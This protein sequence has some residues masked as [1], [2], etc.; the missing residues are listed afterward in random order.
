MLL[1]A[2]NMSTP[3][4]CLNPLCPIPHKVFRNHAAYSRH[5]NSSSG[6][7]HHIRSA[8]TLLPSMPHISTIDK[9][10]SFALT[11]TP[12]LVALSSS[13]KPALLREQF[14]N[15]TV[16]PPKKLPSAIVVD[17]EC[18]NECLDV[19]CDVTSK[20][21]KVTDALLNDDNNVHFDDTPEDQNVAHA[22]QE[23]AT[24]NHASTS[25][26][27][28][29]D[30]L[31]T[32]DQKWTVALLKVL[33]DINAPDYA[34]GS[35]LAWARAASADEYSFYPQG[36]L[37]RSRNVEVLLK[38]MSN[39]TQ[40]LPNVVSVS[41][42]H[43][44]PSPIVVFD[45]VPQLLSLLQNRN[46][47]I[48]QNV[49][50]NLDNPLVRYES[51]DGKL[52]EALSGSVY[53][54]AYNRLITDPT[55][56]LFVPIIQWIDRTSVTGNDRFSLKPY[57]FTP[58]IF[59]E[60]F[61]RTIKAWGYH[62]FLPKS[63]TSSAQNKT[64]SPGDNI[65]NYHAQL[66]Q[67]LESFCNAGPRLKN[68]IL[69]IGPTGTIK[70]DIVTCILFVIQD[71]QEGD[72][73]CGRFGP[74]TPQIQ[75]HCRSCNVDYESLARPDVKCKYLYAAPMHL[76]AQTDHAETRQRWSQH[77]LDNAFNYVTFADPERG[78][79]GATPVET[80]H[81]FRKGLVEVVTYIVLENV[82]ASKKAALDNLALRFHHTH[83][84][85]C[86]H[87]FPSTTFSSGITNISK[88]SASERVG[89]VFLFVI[90]GHFNEGWTILSSAL[91][92]C[93]A[94]KE[95]P[96]KKKEKQK[97]LYQPK[98]RDIL[99]VFEAM[100][101][102]DEW[103]NKETFWL[104]SDTEY[105]KA[106]VSQSIRKLMKMCQQY[107]PTSK[108]NAWNFPKFHELLHILDDMSR[109]GSPLNFCAQR[110]ESLLIQAAKQ[111]GRR[112][113]K[114]HEGALYDLQAAQRLCYSLMIDRVHSRIQDGAP[115]GHIAYCNAAHSN[116]E[117]DDIVPLHEST[118]GASNAVLTCVEDASH[119][120]QRKFQVK[121]ST[122]TNVNLMTVD[123][124]LMHYLYDQFGPQVSFCTQYKRH[125]YTFRC[126]PAFNSGR[127]IYDWMII[128]FTKGLFPCR[129][130]AVV[131]MDSTMNPEEPLQLV[132]Q[133]A[134]SKTKTKSTLFQEWNWSPE[135]LTVSP[136]SIEAPCFVISIRDDHSLILETLARDKWAEQFTHVD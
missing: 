24:H 115:A 3:T 130:A 41:C 11:T 119:N 65:R 86:R 44:P 66:R 58:A 94:K 109:F 68:V 63:K 53:R 18:I 60:P 81:A 6:C 28:P 64:Q 15:T 42:P 97:R 21:D 134:T 83:R 91:E 13:K 57:M 7:S 79:F 77:R 76:I 112:A 5:L 82:P 73:L 48:Q 101:C 10:Q 71:M 47:M 61:R 17:T 37:D 69:P 93:H 59:T 55:K 120:M 122:Q 127:P 46:I 54:D 62:G 116:A 100:L 12:Q 131:F 129:L 78:I 87:T 90:L 26:A 32:I 50:L 128:K 9:R 39:A 114:R 118:K 16:P 117:L 23:D 121:W 135:Y 36:G 126:H 4:Y 84:Q 43:G 98:F 40:L 88:I 124:R 125:I 56:E 96:R 110:P 2:R 45:F 105:S 22:R 33:D 136:S 20:N 70:V 34:F 1:Q 102:F 74:H 92:H 49:V 14:V 107:I 132:V 89:L 99:Q 27:S 25:N 67:V 8:S 95:P 113:Q 30:F 31:H 29:V 103:L 104:Q 35:I 85:T 80:L 106:N 52:G 19:H 108:E 72:M 133:S 75:R 123:I 38:S 51:L 111:P